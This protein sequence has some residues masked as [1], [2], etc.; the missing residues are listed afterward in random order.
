MSPLT[1]RCLCP[2]RHRIKRADDKFLQLHVKDLHQSNGVI[3]AEEQDLAGIK[4][5][6]LL[7]ARI[8]QL[9]ANLSPGVRHDVIAKKVT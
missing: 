9:S 5:Q 4:D 3:G 1:L 2:L 7:M 8:G 6:G